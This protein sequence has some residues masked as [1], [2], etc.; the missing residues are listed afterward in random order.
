ML[1]IDDGTRRYT[2]D[3]IHALSSRELHN[4]MGVYRGLMQK[5]VRASGDAYSMRL[6]TEYCYLQRELQDREKWNLAYDKHHTNNREN[7]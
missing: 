6:E 3:E 2:R 5:N 7:R 4:L 1:S